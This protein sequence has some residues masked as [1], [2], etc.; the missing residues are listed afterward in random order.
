[1]DEVIQEG[2]VGGGEEGGG[3]WLQQLLSH[4]LPSSRHQ[5]LQHSG[6]TSLAIGIHHGNA[7]IREAAV[8]QLGR[9][10]SEG[11]SSI[12]AESG[13]ADASLLARLVDDEPSVVAAVLEIEPQ[14]R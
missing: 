9:A 12:A 14:V 6:S 5:L 3:R 1:M 2:G 11:L 4:S 8:R 13:F 7:A 10:L